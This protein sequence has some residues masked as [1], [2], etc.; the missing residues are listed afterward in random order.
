MSRTATYVIIGISLI[1]LFVGY[2]SSEIRLLGIGASILI[3]PLVLSYAYKH[4]INN[5]EEREKEFTE[6]LQHH[7]IKAPK[8]GK[9][10]NAMIMYGLTN[11]L[12]VAILLRFVLMVATTL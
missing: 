10:G 8:I 7:H 12:S 9:I 5:L 1:V 3:F 2:T 6:N 4:K 11:L